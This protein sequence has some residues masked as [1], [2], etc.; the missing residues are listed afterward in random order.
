MLKKVAAVLFTVVL[1]F[2]MSATI[3]AQDTGKQERIEGKVVRSNA[4]K[5]MLTVRVRDT[6]TEKIVHYDASTK[7]A[8]QYHGDKKVNTIEASDVKDGDQVIALG[9]YD[10]KK[11]FHATTI[12]KRLSHSPK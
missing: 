3:F 11:E 9:S 12:S 10:D 5:S 6:D 2:W 8:S 7:W 4:D 1:V